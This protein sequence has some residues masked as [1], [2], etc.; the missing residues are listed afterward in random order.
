MTL[1]GGH[2]LDS[3]VVE[4]VALPISHDRDSDANKHGRNDK[5]QNPAF[6]SLD[7]ARARTC[8]LGIAESAILGPGQP[9]S[10]QSEK[11]DHDAAE[12]ACKS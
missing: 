11:K 8:R 1:L 4:L 10:R 6:E 7:H 5:K 3:V 2:P 12:P 9:R